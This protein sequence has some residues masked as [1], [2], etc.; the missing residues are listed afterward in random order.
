MTVLN[1]ASEQ[2]LWSKEECHAGA[3]PLYRAG[4][5]AEAGR[6]YQ[7]LRVLLVDELGIVSFLT[8]LEVVVLRQ[9]PVLRFG[10]QSES[11]GRRSR[12]AG[13]AERGA[14]RGALA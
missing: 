7:R 3:L 10:Q 13:T 9:G 5:H 1:G 14:Q 12:Y 6:A 8:T 11:E 4:R 2:I